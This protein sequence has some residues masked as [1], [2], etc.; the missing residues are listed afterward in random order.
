MDARL[1]GFI[2]FAAIY[3]RSAPVLL[4]REPA[5]LARAAQS[6]R[7]GFVVLIRS[8]A[9]GAVDAPNGVCYCY[10]CYSC[11]CC[12]GIGSLFLGVC[13]CYSCYSCYCCRF[14]MGLSSRNSSSKVVGA[15]FPDQVRQAHAAPTIA[16]LRRI[17]SRLP[18][19]SRC[20]RSS[21]ASSR[22]A[23]SSRPPSRNG[24]CWRT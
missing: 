2:S 17:V 3:P 18:S 5:A 7:A 24:P 13:Y 15:S 16:G 19:F 22:I 21:S 1:P 14:A 8:A 12:R 11:Y 23:A 9:V 4:K 20:R 6:P 10:S